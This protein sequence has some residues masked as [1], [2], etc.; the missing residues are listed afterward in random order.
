MVRAPK[1]AV[2]LA[3]C[4]HKDGS[5][6]REAVLALLALDQ[7]G[8]EA[9]CVAPDGLQHH[10]IN[11]GNSLVVPSCCEGGRNMLE[12]SSRIARAGKC[13][14]LAQVRAEDFE[15]LVIPG[16]YGLAKNLCDFAFRGAEAR[17]DPVVGAFIRGFFE[18]H[19]PVGAIC[20]AP[21]LVALA[22]SGTSIRPSLTLGSDAGIA[23]TLQKMG[24]RHHGVPSSREIVVDE[25]CKLV[26]TAAYMFDDARLGDVWIGIDRCVAEVLRMV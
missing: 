9:L 18:A 16:G 21:V 10:V 22:L 19:K 11:H 5:E 13:L 2:L 15:A 7:R 24:A 20:I 6:V 17:I 8:A 4:G 3:G 14:D 25:A 26:T 1:V 23:A 12:E